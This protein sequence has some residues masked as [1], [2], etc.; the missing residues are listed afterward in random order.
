MELSYY[1]DWSKAM[2]VNNKILALI[3]ARMGSTRFSGK[4]M[5]EIHGTPMIGCVYNNINSCSKSLVTRKFITFRNFKI[6]K[7]IL[8]TNFLSIL[9]F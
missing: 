9:I 8:K 3:P 2:I 7:P 4:P 1:G 5:A 6:Y